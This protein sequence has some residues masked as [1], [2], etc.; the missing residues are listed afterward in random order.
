[1]SKSLIIPK[2]VQGRGRG[3]EVDVCGRNSLE[4]KGNGKR[5][6]LWPTCSGVAWIA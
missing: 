3:D 2:E 1:M 4:R 5:L 6:T